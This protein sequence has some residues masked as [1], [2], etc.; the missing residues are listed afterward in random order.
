MKG[1]EDPHCPCCNGKLK[2]YRTNRR[3]GYQ[4]RRCD[5]CGDC[6]LVDAKMTFRVVATIGKHVSASKPPTTKVRIRKSPV[7]GYPCPIC[8]ERMRIYG[9][10]R[11]K[12]GDVSR[13]CLCRKCNKKFHVRGSESREV[14]GGRNEPGIDRLNL[15][16]IPGAQVYCMGKLV[17]C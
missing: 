3:T 7:N 9:S 8:G 5:S 15:A 17:N 16:I 4:S 1:I 10:S 13:F 12:T 2:F 6:F 14:T 11:I